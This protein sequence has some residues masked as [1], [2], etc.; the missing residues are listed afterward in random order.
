MLLQASG[1]TT[2]RCQNASGMKTVDLVCCRLEDGKGV[3][4]RMEGATGCGDEEGGWWMEGG[5]MEGEGTNAKN[6]KNI[7]IYIY[8]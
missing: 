4:V 1:K 7:Y 6:K 3:G 8:M 2:D 5:G